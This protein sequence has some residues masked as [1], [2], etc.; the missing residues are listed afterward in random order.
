MT[1]IIVFIMAA[2]AVVKVDVNLLT[3]A[4]E[5]IREFSFIFLEC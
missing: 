2:A 3:C 5:K 4:N 1:T